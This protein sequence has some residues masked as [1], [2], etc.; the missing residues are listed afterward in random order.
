MVLRRPVAAVMS[1][2]HKWGRVLKTPAPWRPAQL[3][4]G[5]TRGKGYCRTPL[6]PS[7]HGSEARVGNNN[8]R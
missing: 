4:P 1:E 2:Q 5:R 7:T 6:T 3:A 8:R